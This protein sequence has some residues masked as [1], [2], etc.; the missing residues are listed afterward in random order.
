MAALSPD[1]TRL[2][3]AASSSSRAFG[4]V[5]WIGVKFEVAARMVRIAVDPS[6]VNL[7]IVTVATYG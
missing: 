2:M 3:R 4:P 7:E 5:G 1:A 6:A